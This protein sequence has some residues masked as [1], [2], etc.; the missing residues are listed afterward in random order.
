M[1][2]SEFDGFADEYEKICGEHIG[3][4]AGTPEYFAEYKIRDLA[5]SSPQPN[6]GERVLMLFLGSPRLAPVLTRSK[7]I[8]ES[9]KGSHNATYFGRSSRV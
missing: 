9:I 5:D 6:E 8:L 7:I 4:L 1:N 2:N 3:A